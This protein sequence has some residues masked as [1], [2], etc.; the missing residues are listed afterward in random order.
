MSRILGLFTTLKFFNNKLNQDPLKK[1]KTLMKQS[2]LFSWPSR[3][4]YPKLRSNCLLISPG[5]P[6][7]RMTEE[8]PSRT[9]KAFWPILMLEATLKII[10]FNSELMTYNYLLVRRGKRGVWVHPGN[11]APPR[12]GG[13][14]PADT[15]Q[16]LSLQWLRIFKNLQLLTNIK[17]LFMLRRSIPLQL[18]KKNWWIS[19]DFLRKLLVLST[20]LK[21]VCYQMLRLWCKLLNK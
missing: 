10:M 11:Q 2:N 19:M 13:T 17:G 14:S 9:L 8:L 18:R 1:R 7:G 5:I 15:D 16:M 21:L 4:N 20:D 3:N 12:R 6:L